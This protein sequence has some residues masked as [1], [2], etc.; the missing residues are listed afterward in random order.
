ML[1]LQ[2][3]RRVGSTSSSSC[4]LAALG[5]LSIVEAEDGFPRPADHSDLIR[6]LDMHDAFNCNSRDFI[7]K[8]HDLIQRHIRRNHPD[9]QHSNL[10]SNVLL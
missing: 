6:G 10:Y 9:A 3:G 8:S 5:S 7:T 2:T 4:L 1:S